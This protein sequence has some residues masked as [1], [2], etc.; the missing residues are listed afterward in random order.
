MKKSLDNSNSNQ[1]RRFSIFDNLPWVRKKTHRNIESYDR[2]LAEY[3]QLSIKTDISE[4]ESDRIKSILDR[5]QSDGDLR[6]LVSVV[7]E[8]TYKILD[9]FS[10][11]SLEGL[12]ES[13]TKALEIIL[14]GQ[15][16]ISQKIELEKKKTETVGP[17]LHSNQQS[18]NQFTPCLHKLV[19]PFSVLALGGTALICLT[20]LGRDSSWSS[21]F[22]HQR[23]LGKAASV[24]ASPRKKEPTNDG[25]QKVSAKNTIQQDECAH[26][27]AAWTHPDLNGNKTAYNSVFANRKLTAAHS[28][29]PPGAKLVLS[30]GGHEVEVEI[31]DK[32]P[33]SQETDIVLSYEAAHKLDIVNAGKENVV[34]EE[35]EL[36][37]SN[38]EALNSSQTDDFDIYQQ[39]CSPYVSMNG[40]QVHF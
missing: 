29:F 7:D 23:T 32:I 38:L 15:F 35:I 30:M 31:N 6:I 19:L 17:D 2:I 12:E 8:E 9:Y 21:L 14:G 18:A 1:N 5:C 39:Q 20:G 26:Q 22:A 34:I 11:T 25:F 4:E 24:A 10:E 3:Y 36:K 13:R 28:F 16:D 37:E 40:Q 33:P 27:K